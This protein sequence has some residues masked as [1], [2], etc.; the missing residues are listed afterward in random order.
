MVEETSAR[1]WFRDLLA[2]ERKANE[3][4]RYVTYVIPGLLQ[5][6]AYARCC[7]TP[8]RPVLTA[9]EIDRAIA[10][11]M[12]RQDILERENQPRLWAIIDESALRRVNGNTDIMAEQLEHLLRMSERPNVV[13]QIVP[14]SE[15]STVA[16]GREF[17]IMTFP[18]DPPVVYLEDVGS[19]RY[20]RNRKTDE[21]SRYMLTFDH[22]R[23]T[24]LRDDKST[25]FI[26]AL[27]RGYK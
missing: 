7:V 24:A 13:I 4:R 18:F 16:G 21:V 20:V 19:A 9:D 2:V 23:S 22:L 11:R 27:M 15:G 5:T 1:P 10:L 12:S 14:D 8:T 25:E 26:T 3:I 17:T 6:E